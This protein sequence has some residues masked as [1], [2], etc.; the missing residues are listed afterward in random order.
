MNVSC[1]EA[2]NIILSRSF[3][4]YIVQNILAQWLQVNLIFPRKAYLKFF[5]RGL[6][7]GIEFIE[8]TDILNNLKLNM[9]IIFLEL[10]T[11]L[12]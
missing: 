8:M 11:F 9:Q 3:F 6:Q 2:K 4:A 5:V 1:N 10:Y 12:S 7:S